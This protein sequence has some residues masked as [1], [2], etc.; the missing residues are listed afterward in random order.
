MRIF[1]AIDL[2]ESIRTRL[3]ELQGRLRSSLT[4]WRWV[5]P[6]G[7]HLTIRFL[8]EVPQRIDAESREGWRDAAAAVAPFTIGFGALGRFPPRGKPRV[9][10]VAVRQ[11]DRTEG[12]PRLAERIELAARAA[13]FDEET[14]PFRPHLTLARAA[15]GRSPAWTEGIDPAI[16]ELVEVDRLVLFQSTLSPSGARYTALD[17]FAL[18]GRRGED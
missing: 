15:R 1:L 11:E 13:G 3:G 10:W 17:S 4:G 9:M 8:G 14:R 12:L 7:I 16:D 18:E 5:R 6:Q 2:P